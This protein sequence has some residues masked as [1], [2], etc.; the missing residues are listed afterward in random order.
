MKKILFIATIIGYIFIFTFCAKVPTSTEIEIVPPSN[1][2][3]TF[4]DDNVIL[5]WYNNSNNEEGFVIE[6]K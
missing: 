1:L 4:I 3:A 5:E 2:T 6:K